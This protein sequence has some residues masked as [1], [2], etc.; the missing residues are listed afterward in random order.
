MLG[1]T[2]VDLMTVDRRS[3]ASREM[4]EKR[5]ESLVKSFHESSLFHDVLLDEEEENSLLEASAASVQAVRREERAPS[6]P[7]EH[8]PPP[9]MPIRQYFREQG[10]TNSS[11]PPFPL[12]IGIIGGGWEVSWL[13]LLCSTPSPSFSVAPNLASGVPLLRYHFSRP[14][15]V[16]DHHTDGGWNG[17]DPRKNPSWKKMRV[18]DISEALAHSWWT[19]PVVCLAAIC[20]L[21][22]SDA[23]HRK[24]GDDNPERA[25]CDLQG[26]LWELTC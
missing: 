11:F 2:T 4:T 19:F 3:P 13:G 7:M 8:S 24:R 22:D 6:P 17:K 26:T 23:P 14:K 15:N 25:Q 20:L 12:S 9:S 18:R 5:L 10:G 1:C 16:L 21:C